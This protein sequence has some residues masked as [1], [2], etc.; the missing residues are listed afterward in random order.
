MGKEMSRDF[1]IASKS[2]DDTE[3]EKAISQKQVRFM[4]L[5]IDFGDKLDS[6]LA[7]IWRKLT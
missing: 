5:F 3:K 4:K 1:E 6:G 7:K 2:I